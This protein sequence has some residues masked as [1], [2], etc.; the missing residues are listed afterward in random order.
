MLVSLSF[1]DTF[2]CDPVERFCGEIITAAAELIFH[3]KPLNYK[4]IN[5]STFQLVYFPAVC[6]SKESPEFMISCSF[7]M[8]T[9]SEHWMGWSGSA[10]ITLE[11][12][13]CGYLQTGVCLVS[14]CV[15]GTRDS[16]SDG[17]NEHIRLLII[18]P[19]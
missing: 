16:H 8:R 1:D 19:Y 5:H 13:E 2:P 6:R 3:Q 10:G 4:L 11:H 9:N 15:T 7:G 18:W 12:Q 14:K 17:R